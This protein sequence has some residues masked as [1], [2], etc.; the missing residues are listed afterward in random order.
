MT[1]FSIIGYAAAI[2]MVLGYM[3]QAI[4]TIRTRETDSIALPTFLLMGLGSIFFVIQGFLSD[5][6]NWPLIATN[7]ITTVCSA[8]VFGIKM[9]NDYFG[10]RNRKK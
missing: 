4:H 2:C 5:P 7:L 8:T 3:P 1:L 9:H 6:V 10:G